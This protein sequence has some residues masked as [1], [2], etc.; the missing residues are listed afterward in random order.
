MA[1]FRSVRF[2]GYPFDVLLAI[3]ATNQQIVDVA[4]EYG[5]ELTARERKNPGVTDEGIAA[6]VMLKSGDIIIALRSFDG[7]LHDIGVL[8]HEAFH[9][10]WALMLRI[11]VEP[12]EDSEEA[13][14][15]AL[16]D[17]T[18][19]LL[20]AITGKGLNSAPEVRVP[21]EAE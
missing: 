21:A 4:D 11:G 19:R 15:Y 3:G 13:L 18:T 6:T 8:C 20:D 12:S 7:S 10:V 16:Q 17:I 5:I 14:A 2:G 1:E 9:A